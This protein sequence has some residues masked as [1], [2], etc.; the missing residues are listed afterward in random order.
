MPVYHSQLLWE[1]GHVGTQYHNCCQSS[2][3]DLSSCLLPCPCCSY[4]SD[5]HLLN[6]SEYVSFGNSTSEHSVLDLIWLQT[7]FV[8]FKLFQIALVTQSWHYVTESIWALY[9]IPYLDLCHDLDT[10]PY[11]MLYA[12]FLPP[13][14]NRFTASLEKGGK[15][16]GW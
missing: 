9:L 11:M 5:F 7:P 14:T 4:N 15:A 8:C 10:F 2:L 1:Q 6:I 16:K 12:I 13:V 3:I